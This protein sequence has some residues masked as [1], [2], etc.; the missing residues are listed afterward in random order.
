MRLPIRIGLTG[1]LHQPNVTLLWTYISLL[2]MFWAIAKC[3]MPENSVLGLTLLVVL[4]LVFLWTVF[5]SN[6]HVQ[7]VDST[8]MLSLAG[9]TLLARNP[10]VNFVKIVIPLIMARLPI[11][12]AVIPQ[13]VDPQS[14]PAAFKPITEAEAEKVNEEDVKRA[15]EKGAASTEGPEIQAPASEAFG[16]AQ[17]DPRGIEML[18]SE[19]DRE[20]RSAGASASGKASSAGLRG[21]A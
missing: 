21:D 8:E 10:S 9:S 6:N 14:D 11:P 3:V 16:T 5:V 20:G 2:G 7:K 4:V 15:F 1:W 13:D 12:K 18:N 17:L 19:E